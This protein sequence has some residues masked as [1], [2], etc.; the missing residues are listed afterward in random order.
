MSIESNPLS[1][2]A[3]L[4]L[5]MVS[6]FAGVGLSFRMPWSDQAKG[7]QLDLAFG[8]VLA[9]FLVG[10]A[11]VMALLLF[12]GASQLLHILVVCSVLGASSLLALKPHRR[13]PVLKMQSEL[14]GILLIGLL[15]IWVFFLLVNTI[16]LP[17]YQNDALEYAIVG[18]EL[19]QARDLTIYPLLDSESN[20]S[21]FFAP[22]THP[23]LY[24]SM[25]YLMSL[26]Q[27][28]VDEP[29]L[30]R[31][32]A[33]WFLLASV[34]ATVKLGRLLSTN[35]GWLAGLL[36]ISTPLFFLGADSG[37]IDALPVSG[38]V[39]LILGITGL[40]SAYRFYGVV[41]GV[42]LGLTLWTHS[43]AILFV[44]LMASVIIFYDGLRNW[45]K[46]IKTGFLCFTTAL[47]VG[48]YPYLINF[49]LFGSPVS[50]SPAV[51][52]MPELDWRSYFAYARGLDHNVAI[53]QYGLFK[54][55]FSF[56]AYGLLFWLG[57]IGFLLFIYRSK[58]GRF[59]GMIFNGLDNTDCRDSVIWLCL[60]L[61][62]IYFFGVLLSVALGID[63]MIRNERYMLVVLPMLALGGAYLLHSLAT[64]GWKRISDSSTSRMAKDAVLVAF[65]VLAVILLLQLIFVGW[66][67]R[68]NIIVKQDES[69]FKKDESLA[70][71][72][73]LSQFDMILQL[74]ASINVVKKI[75]EIPK[76]AK[77][78]AMRP[79]DMFY[80]D[81]RMVSYL[82]ESLLPFYRD[83]DPVSAAQKLDKL[84]ISYVHMTDYTLPSAYNSS[85]LSILSDP[86]LSRLVYSKGM[87]QLYRLEKTFHTTGELNE[88]TPG[89]IPW[90]RQLRLR[91]GGRKATT[92]LGFGTEEFKG[93]QSV[94]T[95]PIFHRD[96][97]V[98]LATELSPG[99]NFGGNNSVINVR[100]EGEYIVRM[101]LVGEGYMV[102]W[103][104]Q[105]DER[106]NLVIQSTFDR[107]GPTRFG[108]VSLSAPRSEIE[109]V[110]RFRLEPTTHKIWIG[111]EHVG[112][113]HV[114]IQKMTM[115]RILQN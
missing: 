83:K 11:A 61:F 77:V 74:W 89:T 23:P 80:V 65:W 96:Y 33:P 41:L 3:L 27:G 110:R 49:I 5:I 106:G 34:Y 62:L 38:M 87:S 75:N 54:G 97:S 43:Q 63:L 112:R 28:H 42:I 47:L 69:I 21:G 12:P 108:D 56:E 113:S 115:E 79:A 1:W 19:F 15:L 84:G 45:R 17:L 24:V 30:M 71:H 73:N 22:W 18:R 85:L 114:T 46:S 111:V 50:D 9:P 100:P 70:I 48:G 67:Y 2:L 13:V 6:T 51:F 25:L 104:Q 109:F 76:D 4:A 16:Y 58:A 90:T 66:Y 107:D 92:A 59:F 91:I 10:M 8:V 14:T 101:N 64:D 94:S 36:M 53:I 86:S 93:G 60:F 99:I 78:L 26:F 88:L 95:L 44:P 81:R 29:G 68:W 35:I 105:L 82:D 40:N 7:A 39:L 103:L 32:I 52:D 20:S 57:S 72:K 31:L 37:L 102:L 55:W 98:L